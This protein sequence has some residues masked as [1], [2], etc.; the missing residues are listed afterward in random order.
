MKNNSDKKC[1][2]VAVTVAVDGGENGENNDDDDDDNVDDYGD[3]DD[4][5]GTYLHAG[6]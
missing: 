2:D 6:Y 1:V 4:D 3:D 5:D